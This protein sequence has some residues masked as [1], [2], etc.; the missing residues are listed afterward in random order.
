[1]Y[2]PYSPSIS[3]KSMRE[4]V[5]NV[6]VTQDL[7]CWPESEEPLMLDGICSSSLFCPLGL[8]SAHSCTDVHTCINTLFPP[9]KAVEQ[10][11]DRH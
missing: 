9:L 6:S 11:Q 2:S 10:A 4:V 3:D 7:Q 8:R 5:L 1:M